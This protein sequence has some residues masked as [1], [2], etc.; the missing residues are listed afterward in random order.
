MQCPRPLMIA[1][2]A[3]VFLTPISGSA[4]P[5]DGDRVIHDGA[6][7][8][9][10]LPLHAVPGSFSVTWN[11]GPQEHW[12]AD[13]VLP[14]RPRELT[15]GAWTLTRVGPLAA[16]RLHTDEYALVGRHD[17]QEVAR[18]LTDHPDIVVAGPLFRLAAV[19][20]APWR[21]I[22]P[23]VLLQ[24][25]DP[26]DETAMRDLA[27]DLGV[28]VDA[29]RG[30]APDQWRLLVPPGADI[31]PVA[32]AM[33]FHAE[34]WTRWAAVSWIQE[35]TERFVPEDDRFAEQWHLDNTGQ[36]ED[37]TVGEDINAIEAW[38]IEL[39]RAEIIIAM[40]DSGVDTDHPDLAEHVVPGYDF[41]DGDDDPNPT[42]S[43]HGTSGAGLAAAPA[44]GVGVVGACPGC[45]IMPLRMLGADDESEAAALDWG[46]QNGAAVINNSWGPADGT[47]VYTP[48][49]APMVTAVEYAVQFG[50]DGKGVAIL[51]A[52]GNG[53]P[54]DT[55]DLDGFV[56]HPSTIAVGSSSNK[57]LQSTYSESCPELDVLAPSSGGANGTASLTTTNLDGYTTSFG[58]TSAA[59]PV[60]SGVAGLV[61]SALPDLT[62]FH[63]RDVLR[64]S[65]DKIDSDNAAYDDDGHSL[66]H[67]YG[68][69]DALAALELE[70]A[71]LTLGATRAGCTDVVP[72][73]LHVLEASGA[74]TVEVLTTSTAEADGEVFTLTEGDPGQFGG[75][76][77]LTDAPASAGDGF[78]SVVHGD[79]VEVVTDLIPEPSVLSLDCAAPVIS[80][81]RVEV[82]QHWGA[83]VVWDTDE[84]SDG[85]IVWGDGPDDSEEH[86]DFVTL[87]EDWAIN[88]EPCTEYIA[89]VTSSDPTGNTSTVPD[90]VTWTTLGDP[91]VLPEDA[92]EDADP[93][94]PDTWIG[95]GDDDDDDD[96]DDSGGGG[97]GCQDCAGCGNGSGSGSLAGLMLFGLAA[98][99]RRE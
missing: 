18:A 52:A 28:I 71:F 33:A 3:S 91:A 87:H 20:G 38:D 94:D 99:R 59:A 64:D 57:A 95:D 46:T 68:R 36:T 85:L 22:T 54:V 32:A 8:A 7:P 41:I 67:G 73:S 4:A 79:D 72:V 29:P 74:G 27:D 48:M 16:P 98:R 1:L 39:G 26:F 47:G 42:G 62:W 80:N 66:S 19:D 50:R 69:V 53:A 44:Q 92:P 90:A 31:D 83:Q 10:E 63:V 49:H 9:R 60:A 25:T 11:P 84:A 88:L 43:S 14:E 45:L 77:A 12:P 51:W 89:D 65:A 56:A 30:L 70:V 23:K 93:C 6:D 76:I 35:R 5:W 58:G 2:A 37:A 97:E 13:A 96:D 78:L 86:T 15:V 55:C 21:A 75:E 17:P 81:V 24:L 61:L 40:M 82:V 34:P